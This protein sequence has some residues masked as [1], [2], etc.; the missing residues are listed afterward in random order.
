MVRAQAE[1]RPLHPGAGLRMTRR[2]FGPNRPRIV[3]WTMCSGYRRPPGRDLARRAGLRKPS[4][5]APRKRQRRRGLSTAFIVNRGAGRVC[6]RPSNSGRT[7]RFEVSVRVRGHHRA[8]G[9]ASHCL[10][11]LSERRFDSPHPDAHRRAYRES[12]S[13]IAATSNS[14]MWHQPRSSRMGTHPSITR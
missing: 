4:P 11:R 14:S 6:N 3:R 8:V 10:I 12:D 9:S 7:T 1:T 2:D 13:A 5:N